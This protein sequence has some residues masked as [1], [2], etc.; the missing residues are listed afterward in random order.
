MRNSSSSLPRRL[1]DGGRVVIAI[2][3]TS[4]FVLVEPP[5]IV[6]QAGEK[7]EFLSCKN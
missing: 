7:F 6:F 2:Q 3:E 4:E 5:P 1:S